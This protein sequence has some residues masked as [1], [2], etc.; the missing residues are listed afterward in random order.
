MITAL[1][2]KASVAAAIFVPG[3]LT[4]HALG[5]SRAMT[6]IAPVERPA[7]VEVLPG[8]F[9][10]RMAGAFDEAG[11]PVEAPLIRYRLE[12]V[13]DVMRHQ[14]TVAEYKKCAA[15]G[16]CQKLAADAD[17]SSDFPAI[18]V[19]WQ[20][21]T[22]YA[23]WLSANTGE[24][25]RL[26]TDEE[27]AYAAGS[28]VRDD[29]LGQANDPS[30]PAKGWLARYDQESEQ[31]GWSDSRPRPVGSFGANE[32]GLLDLSGNVWEWTNTCFVRASLSQAGRPATV[33]M[34]N[35]GVRVAEGEHR[36]YV[37]NFI[38]D[39]RAGGCSVGKPPSNLGFRLIRERG[40]T[41]RRL[42]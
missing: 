22:D 25:Y 41:L 23:A 28:R 30:D 5:V 7:L 40:E 24:V 3:F 4:V 10:Y 37:P 36:T 39:A 34:A 33:S 13:L 38:R 32:H 27:W 11:R 14:V 17:R 31:Q 29:G 8:S 21:A 12:G 9:S 35:C 42:G 16:A 15:A 19:S 1:K 26:P 18:Q 20:D 2:L 6:T